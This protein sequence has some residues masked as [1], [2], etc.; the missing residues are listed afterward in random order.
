MQEGFI[1][2]V[3]KGG[4]RSDVLGLTDPDDPL[5]SDHFLG[6]DAIRHAQFFHKPL[7]ACL[8]F[9]DFNR[10]WINAEIEARFALYSG[11]WLN[12]SHRDKI[13]E[14]V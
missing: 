1:R 8:K 14:A 13:V 6:C 7:N 2:R 10:L 4:E 11:L 5:L 9:I 3:D 12:S